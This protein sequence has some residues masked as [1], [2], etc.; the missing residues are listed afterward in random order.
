MNLT[1]GERI[2]LTLAL[3]FTLLFTGLA[4]LDGFEMQMRI[5]AARDGAARVVREVG[6]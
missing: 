3:A 2:A 1:L 4:F 5:D 6:R